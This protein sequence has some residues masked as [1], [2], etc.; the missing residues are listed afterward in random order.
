M[1][2]EYLER[3]AVLKEINKSLSFI[4]CPPIIS[5]IVNSIVLNMPAENVE[6]KKQGYWKFSDNPN[7]QYQC[8]ACGKETNMISHYCPRCGACLI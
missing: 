3:G 5:S 8:S 4:D 1:I 2:E 7:C 6:Y